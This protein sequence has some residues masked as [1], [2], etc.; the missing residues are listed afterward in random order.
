MRRELEEI[1]ESLEEGA[2]DEE[3]ERAWEST[4]SEEEG[5]TL[6]EAM[7]RE[8]GRD[9]KRREARSRG[10]PITRGRTDGRTRRTSRGTEAQR[11][12][13]EIPGEYDCE[14]DS[15]KLEEEIEEM[16]RKEVLLKEQLRIL[17]ERLKMFHQQ[18]TLQRDEKIGEVPI[19]KAELKKFDHFLANFAGCSTGRPVNTLLAAARKKMEKMG[20]SVERQQ[21][22]ELEEE[23][24][25]FR[26]QF[27][28]EL[29]LKEE[30]NKKGQRRAEELC[31]AELTDLGV[32]V[33]VELEDAATQSNPV[34]TREM[35]AVVVKVLEEVMKR[36]KVKK[37]GK[38]RKEK[39]EG[40]GKGKLRAKDSTTVGDTLLAKN[41]IQEDE[42]MV[43]VGRFSPYKDLSDYEKE[44]DIGKV[45][46]DE[47]PVTPPVTKKQPVV[48]QMGSQVANPL[49][50]KHKKPTKPVKV[51]EEYFD[52]KAFVVHGILCQR[53]MADTM[54]DVRKT[55]M[56]GIIGARWLLG[57]HRRMGKTTSSVV[58]LLNGLVS[59][60]VQGG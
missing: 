45:G 54:Q 11:V 36:K 12:I 33:S 39:S 21:L 3:V 49:A 16:N 29:R 7:G 47:A 4:D 50:A 58:I 48:H 9:D 35:E 40:K 5:R 26:E 32:Q 56:Q 60:C 22:Q 25:S 38:E 18:E 59:F 6:E 30:Y 23:L 52:P 28:E 10:V 55:G 42:E 24:E 20:R 8:E 44:E 13:E 46:K 15:N 53:P 17:D 1:A 34:E 51:E 41:K 43:D 37:A 31:Q 19:M 27:Y 2:E 57:G 14:G